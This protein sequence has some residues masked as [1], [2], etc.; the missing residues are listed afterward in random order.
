MTTPRRLGNPYCRRLRKSERVMGLAEYFCWPDHFLFLAKYGHILGKTLCSGLRR[1]PGQA[2][3]WEHRP[4]PSGPC[5][6]P[7]RLSRIG[8]T[9]KDEQW[10]KQ[11]ALL[12]VFGFS[13]PSSIVSRGVRSVAPIFRLA[14]L[15]HVHV[16]CT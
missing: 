14:P 11:R 10:A 8:K 2:S 4:S 15:V 1:R 16:S 7:M 5:A 6:V 3:P 9:I 13:S 12:G